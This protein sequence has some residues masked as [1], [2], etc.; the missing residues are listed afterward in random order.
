MKVQVDLQERIIHSEELADDHRPVNS[1][2]TWDAPLE[3]VRAQIDNSGVPFTVCGYCFKAD[4]P[5]N[6][7]PLRGAATEKVETEGPL[8]ANG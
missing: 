1:L 6:R 8:V 2:Q 4:D 5:I 7:R 3:W